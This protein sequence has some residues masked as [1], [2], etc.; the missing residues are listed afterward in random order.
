MN[1]DTSK[2]LQGG[3][4]VALLAI[5]GLLY[6]I[7]NHMT[8]NSPQTQPAQTAA[9]PVPGAQ[10][11]ATP[12]ATAPAAAPAPAPASRERATRTYTPVP[13]RSSRPEPAEPAPVAAASPAPAPAYTP[14]AEPAFP[15]PP[16]VPPPPP[17][18][19]L[20]VPAGTAIS[21]RLLDA[22]SSER[23]RAGD[24]FQATLEEPLVVDGM[25]VADRGANAM[26]RVV[27]AQQSGRVAGVAEMAL[28]IDRLQTVGGEVQIASDTM[29]RRAET[30]HGK[31]AMT[32]GGLAG[33]GAAVGAIAGGRR[34]AGIGAAAGGATGAGTVMATKGKPVKFDPETQLT[35]RLRA[36]ITVTVDDARVRPADYNSDSGSVRPRLSRRN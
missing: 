12:A 10:P 7:R 36:P 35:F 24:T 30:S 5:G 2:I 15:A 19:T 6:S 21:L 32:A 23:N 29:M 11:A 1:L 25:V 17:T 28:E 13:R 3:I 20:T 34:G 22:L 33:L 27:Q 9:A 8:A 4:L 31:D 14:A 16:P 18:R 26:G